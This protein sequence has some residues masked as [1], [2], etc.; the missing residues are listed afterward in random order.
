MRAISRFQPSFGLLELLKSFWFLPGNNWVRRFEIAFANYLRVPA[1][2]SVPSGRTGLLLILK[3]LHLA[4]GDEI[5]LPAFTF[6]GVPQAIVRLGLK[7]VFVDVDPA[8]FELAPRAL[9][10]RISKRTKVILATHLF[11]LPS[12]I[13][14]ICEVATK[15]KIRVI[16][17]CAQASGAEVDGKKLGTFGYAAFFTFGA[18]K[19]LP[20][21][22]GGAVVSSDRKL[23]EK[24]RQEVNGYSSF[25]A[26]EKFSLLTQAIILKLATGRI[27]FPVFTFPLIKLF[28]RL[29]KDIVR[30]LFQELPEASTKGGAKRLSNFQ[31]R[32]VLRSLEKVDS[33]NGARK[34]N[35]KFLI[36][37]LQ[38]S[39]SIL[40]PQEKD[41]IFVSFPLLV[42]KRQQ[43]RRRLRK[44]G[45][46]TSQGY[47]NDCSGLKIFDRFRTNSPSARRLEKEIV[48]IPIY[49]DLSFPELEYIAQVVKDALEE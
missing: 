1:A 47:L 41:N 30:D 11:G 18:T 38:E 25:G 9:E 24:I 10:E 40:L 42:P 46:D 28:S 15:Y 20:A 13:E 6:Y 7:P 2:I 16:E 37:Q 27:I 26:I 14:A 44:R 45:I 17:D 32:L 43:F 49:P 34:R 35:G 12:Q 5:I 4:R 31:A 22:G 8:T 29:G 36:Q 48:H 19:N 33:S 3:N 39:F 23:I 21:L